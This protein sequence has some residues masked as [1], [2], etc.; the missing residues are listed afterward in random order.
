VRCLS[1]SAGGCHSRTC[2]RGEREPEHLG[3]VAT[4][5]L[6]CLPATSLPCHSSA[7]EHE[8]GGRY[9]CKA[10]SFGG[11][12]GWCSRCRTPC[13]GCGCGCVFCSC[14]VTKWCVSK[15]RVQPIAKRKFVI[16]PQGACVST[17]VNTRGLGL[18]A[19]FSV[20]A[21]KCHAPTSR[22]PAAGHAPATY[23]EMAVPD[24]ITHALAHFERPAPASGCH[25][26]SCRLLGGRS[27]IRSAP[28]P[29][30]ALALLGNSQLRI[31]TGRRTSV[32]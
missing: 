32:R 21:A 7:A 29:Q 8:V 17:T 2:R 22:R 19:V 9:R 28:G 12:R 13:R 23:R 11:R 18:T 10:I 16:T 20:A 15:V 14:G 4:T 24:Y 5:T 30:T 31:G 6:P 25:D 26:M 1:P 27:A 3:V